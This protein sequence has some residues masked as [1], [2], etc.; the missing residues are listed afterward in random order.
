MRTTL[1]HDTDFR[2]ISVDEAKLWCRIDGDADDALID[3]L[4]LA[5]TEAAEAFTDRAITPASVELSYN[6]GQRAY[7][8]QT[9]PVQSVTGVELEDCE[10][11]RTA[12]STDGFYLRVADVGTTVVLSSAA[13]CSQVVVVTADVG[14]TTGGE[15]PSAIKQAIAIHVG[16]AYAGRE[17]QDTAQATFQN[18]LRPFRVGGF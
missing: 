7:R 9:A 5:A 3:G 1:S 2:A 18:L 15:V 4:I 11:D 10:G 6:G 8:L 14:Y 17:G 13:P 12:I 16:S